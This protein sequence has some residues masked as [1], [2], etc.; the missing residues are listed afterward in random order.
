MTEFDF[1]HQ[2]A[3]D[4]YIILLELL[5]G[6][7]GEAVAKHVLLSHQLLDERFPFVVLMSRNCCR[8]ADDEGRAGFVDENGIDLIDD[9]VTIATLHLLFAR[10]GHAIVTQVIE[11]E[12]AV[13]SVGDVHRVL[14]APDVRFL[15]VLNAADCE[16]KEIVELPH[17]L[18]IAPGQVIVH[19]HKVRA[20]PGERVQIKR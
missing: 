14:L 4:L 18:R 20:P 10:G 3:A 5:D 16:S 8:P 6:L 15:I 19:R 11:T 9:G 13:C 1:E 12:L 7:A 17:P 2:A